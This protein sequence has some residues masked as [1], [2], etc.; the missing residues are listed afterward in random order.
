MQQWPS[1]KDPGG[2]E[3]PNKRDLYLKMC[4]PGDAVQ[5]WPSWDE[6]S[7]NVRMPDPRPECGQAQKAQAGLLGGIPHTRVPVP[8][9]TTCSADP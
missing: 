9:T 7:R 2:R 3:E 5:A 1:K 6:G 8:L 4:L